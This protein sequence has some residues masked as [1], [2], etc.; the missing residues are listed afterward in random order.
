MNT[1]NV[2]LFKN[3]NYYNRRIVEYKSIADY[4]NNL[5]EAVLLTNINF[6]PNNGI[7]SSQIINFDLGDSENGNREESPSYCVITDNDDLIVSRWWVVEA[8]RIR[9]GQTEISLLRD[10]I[11]DYKEQI[12]E[13]PSFIKKGYLGTINDPA[14]FNNEDMTFNQIKTSE[15]LLKDKSG[16]PWWIGYIPKSSGGVTVELPSGSYPISGEYSTL[17]QHPYYSYTS[18]PFVGPYIDSTYKVYY[19]NAG[20]QGWDKNGN[21]KVP[22]IGT[23]STLYTSYGVALSN[24][25]QGWPVIVGKNQKI[26]DIYPV[27]SSLAKSSTVDWETGSYALTGAHSIEDV[28]VF[29]EQQDTYIR[30]GGTTYQVAI[31]NQQ[32]TRS[33][34]IPNSNP[35]A[36][37]FLKLANNTNSK[38]GDDYIRTDSGSGSYSGIEYTAMCYYIA[39][40]PQPDDDIRYT[41]PVV[42]NHCDDAPYDLV[43]IPASYLWVG[44]QAL[45]TDIVVSKKLVYSLITALT[46]EA[47][48]WQLVPYAPL[49]DDLFINI[50]GDNAKVDLDR[51]QAGDYTVITNYEGNTILTVVF[52]PGSSSFTKSINKHTINIPNSVTEFKVANETDMYRL[53][54]PNYNGQFEFSATKNKGVSGWNIS[55]TL[56]PYN[57]YIRVAP[58]FNGLYGKNF[59]DARGLICGGDFSIS[60]VS[61][62][63]D[64]YELENKN[65]Q[66]MFDRQI[67]NMEVNNSVQRKLENWNILTGTVGGA[68]GGAMFG[69]MTGN[70]AAGVG[71]G[72]VGAGLSLAGG[73]AD[74]N[75]NEKLRQEALSYAQDQFGYQLQNIKALPYSLTKVGSQTTDYKNFPF[76]EYYTC[77]EVEKQALRDKID[78]NGMT[79]GRIGYIS[80]FLKDFT[81]ESGTFI[82]ARPIKLGT[83]IRDDSHVAEVIATELQTGV[84]FV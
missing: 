55:Y 10:V 63:W 74:K 15:T 5:G 72:V 7:T 44:D 27:M 71:G 52:Y 30:A 51:L 32:L 17:E 46:A 67:Q 84:Y 78:W 9:Q 43:A 39:F 57:P 65:Y 24:V 66:V 80:N 26:D 47:Y 6:N 33:V 18:T 83:D 53:C 50:A 41:L 35:Y 13:S 8:K 62:N 1:Y 40:I 34:D 58:I 14:I 23:G 28:A 3:H 48:D 54:S 21:P 16:C 56:K 69:G 2:Y 59:S 61:D 38:L 25:K 36:Q 77:T 49:P 4:Y 45:S 79:I 73:I 11:A 37:N 60:Q 82:Q 31:I 76:V 70:T 22:S 20:Q 75:L 81:D 64:K 19:S 29:L 42:R 12:L 68:V